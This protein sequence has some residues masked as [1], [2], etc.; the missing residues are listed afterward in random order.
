MSGRTLALAAAVA[1]TAALLPHPARAQDSPVSVEVRGGFTAATG[2]FGDG[3]VGVDPKSGASFAGDVY[4]NLSPQLSFYGGWAR[5]AFECSQT[6][7]SG[8]DDL[9]SSGLNLGVKVLATRWGAALPWL[10]VG[11]TRHRLEVLDDGA[12][13]DRSVGLEIAAG[14]DVPLGRHVWV[15]PGIRFYDYTAEFD[16]GVGSIVDD[17]ERDVSYVVFDVG[18][19]FHF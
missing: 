6:G 13:S 10:R 18:L 16:T 12:E 2:D 8:E 4:L 3:S 19:H 11:A 15:T 9:V 14:A 1:A 7:C 17:G 5:H